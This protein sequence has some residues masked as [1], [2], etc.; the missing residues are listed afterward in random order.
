MRISSSTTLLFTTTLMISMATS[1]VM[2]APMGHLNTN[3][4]ATN[5]Y[6]N[7]NATNNLSV[8]QMTYPTDD[9]EE[10][11]GTKNMT[12]NL[13]TSTGGDEDCEEDQSAPQAIKGNDDEDCEDYATPTYGYIQA[14]TG[15]ASAT[16]T[17]TDNAYLPLGTST[18]TP[19]PTPDP[20]AQNATKATSDAM[21]L[22]PILA[23]FVVVFS[24]ALYL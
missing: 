8:Q 19:S 9:C 13:G 4:L 20:N 7:P 22:R 1:G 12:Q 11:Y 5:D 6:N 15:Y 16:G 23:M 21:S 14:S 18:T 2:A 10:E 3:G 24:S 17:P